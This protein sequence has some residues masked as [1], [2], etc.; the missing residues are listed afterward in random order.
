MI[1]EMWFFKVYQNI[2]IL[3]GRIGQ[4]ILLLKMIFPFSFD[5]VF[6]LNLENKTLLAREWLLKIARLI[7]SNAMRARHCYISTW[8]NI[9][10]IFHIF[11]LYK[12]ISFPSLKNDWTLE[13]K[14]SIVFKYLPCI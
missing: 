10:F 4:L 6:I 9:L 13:Y 12:W 14:L 11:Q 5:R 3:T 7:T 1:E 8:P 2:N